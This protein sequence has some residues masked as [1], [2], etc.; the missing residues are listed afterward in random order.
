MIVLVVSV[1]ALAA[2]VEL[3]APSVVEARI[4][5]RVRERT[6]DVAG[7]SADVDSF[8]IV[9]RLLT[10]GRI[11]HM[12][13]TLDQLV[14]QRVTFATVRFSVEGLELDRDVLLRRQEVE[15][16]DIE[17][18]MLTAELTAAVI[19]NLV[20]APV[21]LRPGQVSV[22]LGGTT[23][24]AQPE[25]RD[26]TLRLSGRRATALRVTLPEELATCTPD[27]EVQLGRMVLSCRIQ[28]LPSLL[29]GANR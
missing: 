15:L 9:A 19:S 5:E 25:I 29:K 6:R 28:E 18:G 8:P 4:E 23:V 7:V 13:L 2:G 27:V 21:E 26:R 3:V 1:V 22:T 10:T 16:R 12:T 14:R 20:G 11:R 24:T 17:T